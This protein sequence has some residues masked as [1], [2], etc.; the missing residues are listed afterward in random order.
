M[1]KDL[2][3]AKFLNTKLS[4][5]TNLLKHL[6]M[7]SG[8]IQKIMKERAN[9]IWKSG[10]K[11]STNLVTGEEYWTDNAQGTFVVAKHGTLQDNAKKLG[12]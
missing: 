4:S 6:G 3:F 9:T 10:K 2:S 7:A 11:L 8:N 1:K 12:I 5:K